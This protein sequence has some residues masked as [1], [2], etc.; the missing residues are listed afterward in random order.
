MIDEPTV[1]DGF[2]QANARGGN[3]AHVLALVGAIGF[4]LLGLRLFDLVAV[5]WHL[6]A[7]SPQTTAVGSQCDYRQGALFEIEVE[8]SRHAGCTGA[9]GKCAFEDGAAIAYDPADPSQCRTSAFVDG[10]SPYEWVTLLL[11]SG[12]SF[13]GIA[14]GSFL[15]GQQ[16]RRRALADPEGDDVRAAAR[17]VFWQRLSWFGLASA[18]I[19]VNATAVV[20]LL[21]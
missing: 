16:V 1:L 8:G 9:P 4:V 10:L 12:L 13:V 14:G 18:A 3:R 17:F 2:M 20:A 21:V 5:P 11:T 15:R 6:D 19:T 7:H